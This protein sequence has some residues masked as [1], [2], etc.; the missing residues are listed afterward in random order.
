LKRIDFTFSETGWGVFKYILTMGFI[1]GLLVYNSTNLGYN[2][3]WY[4]VTRYLVSAGENGIE[5]G[6]LLQGLFITLKI[7][8]VGMALSS[9][10]G[11]TAALL[12]LSH[13]IVGKLIAKVYIESIRNTPLLI[14][15][16]LIYFV[17][18]PIFGI[19]PFM[20]AVLALS[21]FEGAYIS[22]IIRGGILAVEKG[23]WE[24]SSSLGMSQAQTY[25]H[26]VLPQALRMMIPPLAGQGIS[27]IK[28][29]ALVS[30]IA[31]YDLTM[32][33]Q[34]IVSETFLV[35]EI[36]FT[37]A[38]IYLSVTA[39]FSFFIHRFEK[40]SKTWGRGN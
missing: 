19:G 28:D 18:A 24:A 25:R 38:L 35:F 39:T 9:I 15:L 6:R 3:Q 26:V 34:A 10:I 29:S 16:L 13:S 27:L 20:S 14:Q 2:W 1:A 22:E 23:Q 7:S 30:V 12:K 31:I 5:A 21:L 17:L 32:E 33:G 11:L 36:W 37:V 8:L 40:S 4:R